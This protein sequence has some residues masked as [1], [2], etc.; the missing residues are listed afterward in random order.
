LQVERLAL[1][2]VRSDC[3]EKIK[4][5]AGAKYVLMAPADQQAFVLVYEL[6]NLGYLLA[7]AKEVF[8]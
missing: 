1:L 6:L 3:V 4:P 8:G 2:M 7:D 5:R